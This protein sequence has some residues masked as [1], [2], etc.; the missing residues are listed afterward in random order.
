MINENDI[1]LSKMSFTDKDFASIYPDLLDLAQTLTNEWNPGRGTNESDPGV[2]LLKEGA[3]IADHN[4]YNIDKNILEAFLPSATQDRSVRNITEMN[5]YVPRYY[6]S[7]TGDISFDYEP[8]E[9]DAENFTAFSIP[10]YTMVITDAEENYAYTQV[11]NLNINKNG[12]VSTC[13]FMEGTLNQLQINN[14]GRI[15]LENLDENNRLY[16]PNVYIPQNGIFIKNY[17]EADNNLKNELWERN[18]YLLTQPL[19]S[20]IYKFDFDS[21]VNLPYVEFPSDI[22]NLIENGLDVKYMSTSG[23][24]GNVDANTLTKVLSPTTFNIGSESTPINI[25]MSDFS[26]N[27][28]SALRNGKNPETINEMYRSFKK[29]VG[30]FDTLVTCRDYSNAIY[31][32]TDDFD[33]PLISNGVVTDIRNDYNHAVNVISYDQYGEYFENIPIS[34][35]ITKYT[36]VTSTANP[37]VGNIAFTGSKFKVCTEVNPEVVWEEI[38]ELSYKDF[39][40]A[41]ESMSQ[42]DLCIYALRAFSMS[43]YSPYSRSAALNNSFTPAHP[44]TIST[45]I[46]PDGIR[47]LKCINHEFM[48]HTSDEV[49]CFKNY[50]PLRVTVTPYSKITDKQAKEDLF[51]KIYQALTMAFNAREVD[52]G[53]ELNYD[54]VY[55]VIVNC[56]DRIKSIRLEDFEYN[57]VAVKVNWK[58]GEVTETPVYEDSDLLVDLVAKNVLAGRLCLFNFDDNF[59]YEYGQQD[60]ESYEGITSISTESVIEMNDPVASVVTENKTTSASFPTTVSLQIAGTSVTWNVEI[61]RHGNYTLPV[62]RTAYV[63][64][65]Q[66]NQRTY[67]STDETSVVI[68]NLSDTGWELTGVSDAVTGIGSSQ[69]QI[70]QTITTTST[71]TNNLNYVVRENEY[72]QIGFP[73]YYSTKIYPAYVYWRFFNTATDDESNEVVARANTE[74]T[75]NSG[76]QLVML[77]TKDEVQ[78]TDVYGPGTVIRPTFNMYYTSKSSSSKVNRTWNYD[79]ISR[80][81][82][83]FIALSSGQQIE[84]R[85]ILETTLNGA[86][87]PCYWIRNNPGNI[88]FEADDDYIILNS[89]EY[90]IYSNSTRDSMVILG[91][92]TKITKPENDISQWAIGAINSS[93]TNISSINNEGFAADIKWQVKDFS[94]DGNEL[95]IQEMNILTLGEG[96][97]ITIQGLD[98]QGSAGLYENGINNEWQELSPTE[99]FKLIYTIADTT[100]T[101]EY[102]T[103]YNYLIRSRLDVSVNNLNDQ[104]LLPGQ[105]V[106]ITT[107]DSSE[108]HV[109]TTESSGDS[110]KFQTSESVE[111]I[112]DNNI[113]ITPYLENNIDIGIMS[114]TISKPTLTAEE[115]VYYNGIVGNIYDAITSSSEEGDYYYTTGIQYIKFTTTNFNTLWDANNDTPYT[116]TPAQRGESV[117]DAFGAI[118]VYKSNQNEP[119][120][121]EA[122]NGRY[123]IP[124]SGGNGEADFPLGYHVN[125]EVGSE[126]QT[127]YLLPVYLLTSEEGGVPITV[128][129]IDEETGDSVE[130]C[131]YNYSEPDTSMVLSKEGMYIIT[132]VISPEYNSSESS[133]QETGTISIS[134][135]LTLKLTWSSAP[136]DTE[137]LIIL[138]PEVI[139]GINANLEQISLS[140]VLDRI[141]ELISNSDKYVKPYY[142]YRPDQ[143]LAIQDENIMNPNIFWDK[144][145]VANIITIPQIDL[146]NSDFAITKSMLIRNKNK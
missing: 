55:D 39:V 67:S 123:I 96:S 76:E 32:I 89:G 59:N 34:S 99:A 87:V 102:N 35:G 42:Y 94:G 86:N 84:I 135:N 49:Y 61:P 3:F 90:F 21:T 83:Q 124:V 14:E 80:Q 125:Y 118:T 139:N 130:I 40:D 138:K 27:N 24:N 111:F 117:T 134:K 43:D 9:E 62:G 60:V 8:S 95:K 88:L 82:D 119:T 48:D 101:L 92:G 46:G 69:I 75:L 107:T 23:V 58:S 30:T 41:S 100:S 63:T 64:T 1:Q 74:Y 31:N 70:S 108:E 22:A 20:K 28:M 26:V 106:T 68:S 11:T 56:D 53:E 93:T 51:N 16:L 115:L 98:L 97:Q 7:A 4:N 36:F 77:Y 140:S 12:T 109:I 129:L 143:D 145:N 144:N 15:T 2:V 136:Q 78:K 141:S 57:P 114:Y 5:G 105:S 81:P 38:T 122:N 66:D 103:S 18:N 17:G 65:S 91:A 25:N 137:G 71:I 6:V 132:P 127:Q 54:E 146:D 121:L 33:N 19:G 37:Q 112:G 126:V 79:G 110:F 73:N 113:N 13:V 45:L 116:D 128:E 133:E 72:I 120:Y 47:G 142:V 50:V 85:E 104:T 52:F 44:D 29:I 131:D 10:A